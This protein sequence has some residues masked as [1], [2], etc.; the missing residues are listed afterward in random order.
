MH[1]SE[2]IHH[3]DS[4]SRAERF[5]CHE[6]QGL[7][8]L[9]AQ[10]NYVELACGMSKKGG[11]KP[12]SSS[13]K[14]LTE[15]H[16]K[17]YV[18]QSGLS[19][20]LK[21]IR[22][23]GL[24]GGVSRSSIKRA[25]DKALPADLWDT[26]S[27]E[28]N[29]GSTIKLPVV[30][31]VRL[32][33]FLLAEVEAFAL[34]FSQQ[35]Q[36]H[37]NDEGRPWRICCYADEVMPG[38]ALKARNDRKLI[39]FYVS[40]L[41]FDAGTSCED[42]WFTIG[43]ARTSVMNE[44]KSGWSQYFCKLALKFFE[45]PLDVSR[46]VMCH[47]QGRASHLLFA[48][49]GAVVADEPALKALWGWKGSSG[50]FPCFQCQNIVLHKLDL[51]RNDPSGYLQSH[52]NPDLSRVIRH[53]DSSV[54]DAVR[55]LKQAA[56]NLSHAALERR[57]VALGVLYL[58]QGALYSEQLLKNVLGGPISVSQF[59]WM[60]VFLVSGVFQTELTLLM[61]VLKNTLTAKEAATSLKQFVFPK[62]AASKAMTGTKIFDKFDGEVKCAASEALSIYSCVRSILT[63]LPNNQPSQV[64]LAKDSF[65]AL[66]R[67]LDALKGLVANS[68]DPAQLDAL[69]TQHLTLRERCYG[70]ENMQPKCHYALHIAHQLSKQ[71]VLGCFVHERKHKDLKHFGNDYA[72]ANRTLA[73]EQALLKQTCLSQF[74]SL[75]EFVALDGLAMYKSSLADG[76]L[77]AHVKKLLALEAWEDVP[78]YVSS[79]VF[80][81]PGLACNTS[82][83]VLVGGDSERVGE[84]W[85]HCRAGD[86]FVTCWNPWTSL[87]RNCFQP[88]DDSPEFIETSLIRR[89]LVYKKNPDGSVLVVP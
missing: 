82:D 3:V 4:T 80:L 55:S 18:S 84:V 74:N 8:E 9:A 40:F 12:G 47:M 75:K 45:A 54:M 6:L 59:D 39:A 24:P 25:R 83:V 50:S 42:L 77:V 7:G 10:G 2:M 57:E 89:P 69:V 65:Y 61:E 85:V 20:V 23:H 11:V 78:V 26:I 87:G 51:H 64:E 35:L 60:H 36:R 49:I 21:H 27:I 38:A 43:V 73:F 52:A 14:V 37:P 58:E 41:E 15:A 29:D 53:T 46:G 79:E 5:V 16:H 88:Q 70:P 22:Q 56:G 17:S 76:L 86:R 81:R 31:P 68:L 62:H 71:R 19:A 72:N 66:C 48:R 63:E 13:N 32:I 33:R 67:A 30:H 44:V 1:V 34:F 28:Q